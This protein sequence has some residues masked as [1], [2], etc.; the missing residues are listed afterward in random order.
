MCPDKGMSSVI[1]RGIPKR[2][3]K[4]KVKSKNVKKKKIQNEIQNEK[5]IEEHKIL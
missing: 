3:L 5:K 4:K 1:T 2:E